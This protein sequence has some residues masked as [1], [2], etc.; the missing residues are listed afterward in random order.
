MEMER[1]PR[2]RTLLYASTPCVSGLFSDEYFLL[3]NFEQA[4]SSTQAWALAKRRTSRLDGVTSERMKIDNE[5][6]TTITR[7]YSFLQCCPMWDASHDPS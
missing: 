6:S 4:S 3:S 5:W 1:L 2:S 7:K